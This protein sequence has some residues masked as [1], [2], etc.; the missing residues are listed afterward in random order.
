LNPKGKQRIQSNL[1]VDCKPEVIEIF[2]LG[3]TVPFNIIL[4][5]KETKIEI[6]C[7]RLF[8]DILIEE[9]NI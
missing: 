4:D 1:E 7:E 6:K 8:D 5:D 2:P 3:Y 9:E